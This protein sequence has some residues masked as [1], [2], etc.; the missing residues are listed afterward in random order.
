MAILAARDNADFRF[1]YHTR[2]THS[3]LT[4][5][6]RLPVM[7]VGDTPEPTLISLQTVVTA[8]KKNK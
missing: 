2:A 3:T 1:A 5:S 8:K 7:L 6:Q 4:I